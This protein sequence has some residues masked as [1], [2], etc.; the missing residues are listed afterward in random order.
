MDPNKYRQTNPHETVQ[1]PNPFEGLSSVGEV[2]PVYEQLLGG[3]IDEYVNE[4]ALTG[5]FVQGISTRIG[6]IMSSAG[7]ILP[8]MLDDRS[9]GILESLRD[10]DI[11]SKRIPGVFAGAYSEMQPALQV[12][13]EAGLLTKARE[14]VV[15]NSRYYKLNVNA[16]LK[17]ATPFVRDAMQIAVYADELAAQLIA[18]EA[19][20]SR[21]RSAAAKRVGGAALKDVQKDI[22]GDGIRQIVDADPHSEWL[23]GSRAAVE[24]ARELVGQMKEELGG[25]VSDRRAILEVRRRGEGDPSLKEAV[26]TIDALTR[27]KNDQLPF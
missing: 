16:A 22:V 25:D 11:R 14:A 17:G 1:E 24:A 3:A 10:T 15:P 21:R 23:M 5:E 13:R 12:I 4:P 2:L 18:P 6:N 8:G 26:Q 9:K 20:A 19:L 7:A 27:G